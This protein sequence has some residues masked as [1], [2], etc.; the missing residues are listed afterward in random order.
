[1][2]VSIIIVSYNTRDLLYNCINSIYSNNI[3]CDYEVI[4]VDNNSQDDSCKM[5]REEFPQVKLIESPQNL[6]FG[7]ANNLGITHAKGDYYLFLNS[8]TLLMNNAIDNFLDYIRLNAK[9]HIGAL[10]SILIN[11]DGQNMHSYGAFL[12]IKYLLQDILH[13]YI[14]IFIK[15]IKMP[16]EVF[17]CPD[18][19]ES[20]LEV[21]YIT[22][23]DL[24]VPADIVRKMGA[25]DPIFFMYCEEVDWQKRMADG[26][27]KR[28]IINGPRIIHLEGASAPSMNKH[29]SIGRTINTFTSQIQYIRKHNP[30]W[31]Y[32]IFRISFAL[33]WLVPILVRPESFREKLSIIK[34]LILPSNN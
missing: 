14:S 12:S 31:K 9:E 33:L 26:G 24:F 30:R 23:A 22:G 4:V 16:H 1:M 13:K 6:G 18:D 17:L 25:F 32:L 28:I 3:Q 29:R 19:V 8:D 7:R 20:S 11:K 27:Y 15:S 21:D 2:D 10:G 5:L 34:V